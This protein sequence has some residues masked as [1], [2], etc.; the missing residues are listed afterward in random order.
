MSYLRV[1][2]IQ[3]LTEGPGRAAGNITFSG[4]EEEKFCEM[5]ADPEIYNIITKSIAPYIFGSEDMK[6]PSPACCLVRIWF[7]GHEKI[8]HLLVVWSG[9][10]SEDMK[11]SITCLAFG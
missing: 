10:G 2:G 3:V 11:R 8:H 7:R 5:A 1:V 9:F 4:E 6:R